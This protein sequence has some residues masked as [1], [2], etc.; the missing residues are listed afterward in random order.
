MT[1]HR[2]TYAKYL[3]PW[4][5]GYLYC[6]TSFIKA[7]TQALGRFKSCLTMVPDG[8]KAKHLS[9]V[10]HIT[11][12]VHHHHDH[13]HHHH[14]HHL[15]KSN[16]VCSPHVSIEPSIEQSL[17]IELE[18]KLYCFSASVVWWDGYRGYRGGSPWRHWLKK[19]LNLTN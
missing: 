7:W 15:Q 10:N 8:N 13:H 3:A 11:K 16:P 6:T 5:N 12:T 14:H 18:E 1:V 19:L 17:I 4:C 2:N 9:L